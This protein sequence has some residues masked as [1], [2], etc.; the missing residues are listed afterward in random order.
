MCVY[1]DDN[2]DDDR[3][4]K[5]NSSTP[6]KDNTEVPMMLPSA[7]ELRANPGRLYSP[8]TAAAMM[9]GS[10]TSS[11]ANTSMPDFAIA[12]PT[13]HVSSRP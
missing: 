6:S 10:E 12:E 2:N 13:P 7:A 9:G 3:N 1:N 11:Q 8:R 5:N 4:K